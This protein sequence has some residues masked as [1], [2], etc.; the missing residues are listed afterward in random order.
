MIKKKEI[1]ELFNNYNNLSEEQLDKLLALIIKEEKQRLG[2]T[3]P[4]EFKI[5]FDELNSK[6]AGGDSTLDFNNDKKQWQYTVRLNG[7]EWYRQYLNNR[8]KTYSNG[9][10]NY[11]ASLDSLYNLIA[12][13]CHEMRH[14]YQNEMT[15]IKSD[16]SN[17]EA[18]IWLKQELVV[19][20]ENFY[21]DSHNYSNMPREVDAFKYQYNRALDYVKTYTDIEKNNPEFY[22]SLVQT[23]NNNEKKNVK[24]LEDLTFIVNGQK[25]SASEYFNQNMTDAFKANGITPEIIKRSILRYEYNPDGTKK[26]LE[27][28]MQDKQAMIDGLDKSLS[29]YQQQVGRIENIYDSII[30]NDSNLQQQSQQVD[31]NKDRQPGYS[32]EEKGTV[33]IEKQQQVL[34]D[35]SGKKIGNSTTTRTT[36]IEKGTEVSDT[37]GEI[38]D[39]SGKY[40][41]N[42]KQQVYG[43]ELQ[44]Q[45]KEITKFNKITGQ[46]EQYVYQKDKNGNEIYYRR[47]EGKLT[48][49]ITRNARGT[50]IEHYDNGQLTDTFEYDSDGNAL[51][52]QEGLDSIDDNYIENYFETNI[53]YFIAENSDLQMQKSTV[54][55][56]KLGKETLDLQNG[57]K[58]M[59][60]VESELEK[61][62]AERRPQQQ[63]TEEK[64]FKERMRTYVDFNNEAQEIKNQVNRDLDNGTFGQENSKSQEDYNPEEVDDDYVL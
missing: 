13:A 33:Y 26:S 37:I 14:A 15:R 31:E 39:D 45:R 11:E 18:L 10:M 5:D 44:L 3:L 4:V 41:I 63:Q 29:N 62:R 40:K 32:R 8:N 58:K 49:R 35:Y 48:F 50:T 21:R 20:D 61:Q 12:R 23:A 22:N 57:D 51:I 28:L 9:N 64:S 30:K 56:R 6:S 60:D 42:E 53:P 59:D 19:P 1:Q 16:L 7:N 24:P 38:E 47:A 46:N 27:Q 2:L 36:D 55:T 43:G 52:G 17:P 34:N 25:I 54:E